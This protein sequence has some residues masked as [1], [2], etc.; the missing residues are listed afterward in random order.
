MGVALLGEEG[1]HMKTY[2]RGELYIFSGIMITVI[3]LF[4]SYIALS[5]YGT[6]G[7]IAV[8]IV[9]ATMVLT[10]LYGVVYG[11][12]L[13]IIAVAGMG[14]V[15]MKNAAMHV[16]LQVNAPMP[17]LHML[18]LF[19]VAQLLILTMATL[20]HNQFHKL[21]TRSTMMAE[22]IHTLIAVDEVTQFDNETRMRQEILRE[23]KRVDRHGGCFT[24]LV[25]TFTHYDEFLRTYG[26]KE[27]QHVLRKMAEKVTEL[28]RASDYKYR[29]GQ[30]QFVFLL[31]E[32]PEVM[33]PS[34]VGKLHEEARQHPLLN[35]RKVTLH[36]TIETVTYNDT[37]RLTTVEDLFS[38]T[39]VL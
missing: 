37:M 18:A 7:Y 8:C 21:A 1:G 28:L 27:L 34:V 4:A 25:V 6:S 36:F 12:F 35:G 24:M 14:I 26:E 32:T 23:M 2:L 17:D 31:I 20:L 10:M 19:V 13:T 38:H 22:H 33:M 29:F 39:N 16:P 30:Q 9:G 3:V 11:G 15:L 5:S